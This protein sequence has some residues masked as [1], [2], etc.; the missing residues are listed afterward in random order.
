MFYLSSNW[1]DIFKH[2]F[3]HSGGD[4]YVPFRK[5]KVASHFSMIMED[6]VLLP[7]RNDLAR[8]C[9][10]LQVARNLNVVSSLSSADIDFLKLVLIF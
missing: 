4:K 2:L 9:W 3:R 5:L 8:D 7:N 10:V 1:A 6:I